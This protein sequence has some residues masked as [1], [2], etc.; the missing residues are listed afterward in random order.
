MENFE[1][2]RQFENKTYNFDEEYK[3]EYEDVSNFVKALDE[4]KKKRFTTEVIEKLA[5][6]GARR[7][8]LIS[9]YGLN[10]FVEASNEISKVKKITNPYDMLGTMKLIEDYLVSQ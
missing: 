7:K 6:D 4:N 10:K 1:H 5:D 8:C 2:L 3:K 9:I